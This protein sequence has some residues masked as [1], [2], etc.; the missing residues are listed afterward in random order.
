M[1]FF[2][3]RNVNLP[4]VTVTLKQNGEVVQTGS[5]ADVMGHPADAV[6]WLVNYLSEQGR[7]VEA[8]EIIISGGMTSAIDLSL[9]DHIEVDFGPLGV[10]QF[11]II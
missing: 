6:V 5:G 9:H 7:K 3:V 2:N 1:V 10:V 11:H 8:G 4:E